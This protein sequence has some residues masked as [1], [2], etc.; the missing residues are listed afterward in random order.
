MNIRI[1]TLGAV[2]AVTAVA[3]GAWLRPPAGE[4]APIVTDVAVHTTPIIQAT[5]RR[6][7]TAY[8]YVDPE[9]VHTGTPSAAGLVSPQ[10]SG[11]VATI[12]VVEGQRV[13]RG[14]ILLRLDSRMAEVTVQKAERDVAFAET[15]VK[16]QRQLLP[17]DGTSPRAV[18]EAEQRLGQAQSEL[19]AAQTAR[20]YLDVT[21]PV[22]GTVVGLT[23]GVGQAVDPGTV[24]AKIIDLDRLVVTADLP[25]Q[26]VAG[27]A[28]GQRV[29]LG[30][31][32]TARGILTSL[33]REIDRQT[34]TR[35]VQASLPAAAGFAPGQFTDIRITAEERPH[36]LVVPEAGVVTQ[37]AG[38]SWIVVVEGTKATRRLVTVGIREA[39]LVEI[40]GDGLRPGM[41]VVTIEAYSLPE[42]TKIHPA[43]N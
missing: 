39:G 12:E 25:Y 32:S 26:E 23:A 7:V 43:G 10:I 18:Q 28:V 2:V 27:L 42:R 36:V 24:L 17:A 33:S 3:I 22:T 34:G 40:S 5:L 15:L 38:G 14:A 29:L 19:A 8:G 11:V 1:I 9:P 30:A 4:D 16:R 31:D 37:A 21:A 6:Y 41:A 35:R 20:A 13:A